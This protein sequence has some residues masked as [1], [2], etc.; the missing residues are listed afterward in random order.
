M[1]DKPRYSTAYI[2]VSLLLILLLL[3]VPLFGEE[4]FTGVQGIMYMNDPSFGN[5]YGYFV[6]ICVAIT[7]IGLILNYFKNNIFVKSVR[8]LSNIALLFVMGFVIWLLDDHSLKY[9][10]IA[11]LSAVAAVNLALAVAMVQS[12]NVAK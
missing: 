2:C 7:L 4:Y 10:G 9:T 6:L 5:L 3:F 11:F 12:K 1:K 8:I